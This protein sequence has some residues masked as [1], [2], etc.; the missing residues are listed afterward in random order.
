MKS[1]AQTGSWRTIFTAPVDGLY[2]FGVQPYGGS[3]RLMRNSTMVGSAISMAD[4]GTCTLM[5]LAGDELEEEGNAKDVY[6]FPLGD[7]L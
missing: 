2:L 5:M 3:L 6:A 1:F 7:V 4:P